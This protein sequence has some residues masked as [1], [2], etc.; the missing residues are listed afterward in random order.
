MDIYEYLYERAGKGLF[1]K[2]T[3]LQRIGKD[4]FTISVEEF[5]PDSETLM[6]DMSIRCLN[7]LPNWRSRRVYKQTIKRY[8]RK[9]RKT[10]RQVFFYRL[11]GM[12]KAYM[13]RWEMEESSSSDSNEKKGLR[14]QY[15][16]MG[17]FWSRIYYWTVWQ[18]WEHMSRKMQ[19]RVRKILGR[20]AV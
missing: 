2:Q 12:P 17:R 13:I 3:F 19:N 14:F 8:E 18:V 20:E 16:M 5:D 9:G 6:E 7:A 1:S 10:V 15:A 4:P 11:Y